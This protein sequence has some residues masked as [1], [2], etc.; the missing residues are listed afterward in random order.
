[1]DLLLRLLEGRTI[2]GLAVVLASAILA[3]RYGLYWLERADM[4]A[5]P[6]AAT[7]SPLAADMVKDNEARDKAKLRGLYRAVTAD[8]AAARAEGFKVEE[9]QALA[10]QIYAMD[11]PDYRATA[12]ERLNRL[13][14]AIPQ[15]R[16]FS[17]AAAAEDQNPD[18]SDAPTPK[19]KSV[20]RRR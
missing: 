12:A 6:P 15:K 8:I 7:T 2:A 1:M 11:S 9:M 18:R 14:L 13:R 5:R 17:R 16:P 19:T 20:K 3:N 10:D 4:L